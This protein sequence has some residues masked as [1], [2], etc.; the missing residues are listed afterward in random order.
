[1]GLS[2]CSLE[3]FFASRRSSASILLVAFRFT[4][5]WVHFLHSVSGDLTFGLID[6]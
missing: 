4:L 1:M 6:S 5:R 2:C 3:S